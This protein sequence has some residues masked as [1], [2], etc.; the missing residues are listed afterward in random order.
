M[1]RI[2]APP[3]INGV[4]EADEWAGRLAADAMPLAKNYNGAEAARS[5]TAWLS[6]DDGI[7]YIAV[8]NPVAT[9]AKLAGATWG[10]DDAVEFS[11]QALPATAAQPIYIFRGYGNG[12]LELGRAEHGTAELH[13]APASPMFRYAATRPRLDLWEAEIAIPLASLG[14]DPARDRRLAFN[15]T[16]RKGDDNLWLMWVA[17][18]GN[19]YNVAAAGILDLQP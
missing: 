18:R 12:V 19:S 10:D 17:T 9:T 1:R 8:S 16:V 11:L 15:L 5:S 6:H 4:I 7:L 3:A 14:I 13:M 2:N